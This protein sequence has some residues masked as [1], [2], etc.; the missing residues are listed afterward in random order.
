LGGSSN[1]VTVNTVD[2][3]LA[4]LTLLNGSPKDLAPSVFI[5]FTASLASGTNP[6]IR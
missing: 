3:A 5:T 2:V 6:T 1:I 4:G